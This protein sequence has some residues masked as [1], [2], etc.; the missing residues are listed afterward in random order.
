MT[1]MKT[2]PILFATLS[3]I[4]TAGAQEF[5]AE[6][7]EFVLAKLAADEGRYDEA[8]TRIDRVI[9]AVPNEPVLLFERAMILIDSGQINR[10][11]TELRRL[12]AAHPD[13]Y[14]G[15][16]ILG[17]IILDRS[18]SDRAKMEEALE[19]LQAA[20]KANPDDLSTGVTVSQL[21][22][23]FDRTAEAERVLATLVERAPDQRVLNYNYAQVLTKLGRGDESKPY[24]ERAVVLDPTFAPAIMQL[25]DLYQKENDWRRA[26]EVLQPLIDVDPVNIELQRQQAFFWLRAGSADKARAAF[27]TLVEANPDDAR[28]LFYLAESLNDLEQFEESDKIYRRLLESAPNDPD[29]LASFGLSQVGQRKYDEAQTTFNRLLAIEAVPDNL[30]ALA[31]TQLAY[32][33]LQRGNYDLAVSTARPIFVFRDTPNNQAINI[34]LEALKKQKRYAEAVELLAPLT[35][36]FSAEPFINARYVE[37]LVRA[38]ERQKAE[39]AMG[40]QKKFGARNVIATAEGLIQA[41]EAKTAVALV[42]DALKS[43]PDDVDLMFE[44]GSAYERAGDQPNAE[45][46]FLQVL[47]K[48]PDHAGTLN[49]LGYMWADKD[50]NLDR[51]AEMLTRAVAQEPRNGAYVDSLGWLYFRQGKLDLAEKYLS[52]AARLLPRDATVHEHLADVLAKRGN[53]ERALELYRVALT[54]EPAPKDEEKIRSKIAEMERQAQ[55]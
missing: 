10:A 48:K 1:R 21:L 17:R 24:L 4:A 39:T 34:A 35:D 27:K 2:L 53:L 3:L 11:E 7:Y 46:T 6:P 32:I 49:Y 12:T 50:V 43:K 42:A 18:G 14:D 15:Q 8:L 19:H 16:R 28:S 45:R 41:G 30:A 26:A 9:G 44:L 22:V 38:G 52:D 23:A 29:L 20:F 37:M 54:L 13:F 55:R 31:R 5:P 40:T 47:Q 36:R 33:E 25:V 51:A